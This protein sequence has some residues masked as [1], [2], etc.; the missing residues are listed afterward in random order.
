[1][2]VLGLFLSSHVKIKVFANSNLFW[3]PLF[4]RTWCRNKLL[5]NTDETD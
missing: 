2:P 1:M 5:A 4:I 3:G